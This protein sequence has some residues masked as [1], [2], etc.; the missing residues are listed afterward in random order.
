MPSEND[1]LKYKILTTISIL[2]YLSLLK[3]ILENK[4]CLHTLS[5]YSK[6]P[7]LCVIY[8]KEITQHCCFEI[9]FE[10]INFWVILVEM[11]FQIG[12]KNG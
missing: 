9:N 8:G 12:G 3:A 5:A 6:V 10:I 1:L 2:V 11:H 4:D 7:A